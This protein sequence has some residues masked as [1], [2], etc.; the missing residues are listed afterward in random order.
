[1]SDPSDV[2]R[3]RLIAHLRSW[4]EDLENG[5]P[6][7]AITQSYDPM[8]RQHIITFQLKLSDAFAVWSSDGRR[9]EA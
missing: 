5:A 2:I 6:L 3:L 7:I 4:V 1:M 8:G 9:E